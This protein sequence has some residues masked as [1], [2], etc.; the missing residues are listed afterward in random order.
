M[1]K[2]PTTIIQQT[3]EYD[4]TYK[5]MFDKVMIQLNVHTFNYRCSECYRH[6]NNCYCYRKTCRT[7]LRFCRQLHFDQ[8]SMTEDDLEQIIPMT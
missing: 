4:P 2:L 3:Y 6:Y 5:D 7:F 8:N 1:D